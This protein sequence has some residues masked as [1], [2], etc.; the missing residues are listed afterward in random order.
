MTLVAELDALAEVETSERSGLPLAAPADVDGC[1]AVLHL[2]RERGLRVGLVGAGSSAVAAGHDLWLSTR[3]LAGVVSYEPG[4]GTL[5]ALAGTPWSELA[6]TVDAGGHHLSPALA[7]DEPATLG[8]LVAAGRSGFDRLRHGPLRHQVLGLRFLL[9]DGTEAKSG[10]RLV[11]NVT[12]YDLHR[13]LAGSHGRLALILEASLRLSPRPETRRVLVGRAGSWE[14]ALGRCRALRALPLRPEA[15]TVHGD[16]ADALELELHLA[17]R[18]DTVAWE[19]E[20]ARALD[21]ELSEDDAPAERRR[22][23]LAAERPPAPGTTR[24]TWSTRPSRLAELA[25]A[26]ERALAEAGLAA[27]RSAH[28]G[29]ATLRLDWTHEAER[30]ARWLAALAARLPEARPDVAGD[31]GVRARTPEGARADWNE[32]LRAAL[33]PG[34]L[35]SPRSAG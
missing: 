24:A 1:R 16:R 28:A 13:L 5:T 33:D 26:V 22:A 18:A 30:G 29:V 11:K 4:D 34:A 12:G 9:A 31:G 14:E 8:G 15:L 6:R 20:R 25:T 23:R 21:P 19:S 17:G 10:G 35:F 2:A 27:T 3:R 7:D 32:R